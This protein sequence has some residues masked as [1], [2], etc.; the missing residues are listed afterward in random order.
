MDEAIINSHIGP[1]LI[2]ERI[3]AGGM[4]VVYKATNEATGETV[5]LKLL[6]AGWAEHKEVVDR[7]EREGRI[8][9]NLN[10][11]HIVTY[12]DAGVFEKTRPY[13]VMDYL[14]G[15]SLSD[16]LK[17]VAHIS[18]LGASRLLDQIGSALDYAHSKGVVHR[19]M[20]PGNIL[21]RDNKH[22]CLTDFGIARVL[23]HTQI[24]TMGQMPGTP[25]YM[26]PEQARGDMELTRASD[27]YS[28][29][30]IA[31]LLATG[32]LPFTGTDPM[33]ILNQHLTRQP[34]N[35]LQINPALPRSLEAVLMKGL[36]KNPRDRFESAREFT[37]AFDEAVIGRP[38]VEVFI[39]VKTGKGSNPP[40]AFQGLP[41]EIF[42]ASA[43]A[44]TTRTTTS[45]ATPSA[46][47]NARRGWSTSAC[48][49]SASACWA[50]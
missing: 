32:S 18:L 29:A 20:K 38:D 5:A 2:A 27:L 47:V 26:S 48:A 16:R 7:F 24:T 30:V 50:V 41:S 9:R 49:A 45:H 12:R 11:P 36:E 40:G 34:P 42:S 13:I 44:P 1:Y 4:A 25:Q 37:R 43:P 35:P 23:E 46:A 22:A 3:K 39:N 10:H 17:Q 14:P 19:D 33:V 6:Q 8:M 31:Y 21:L 28:L 15:G